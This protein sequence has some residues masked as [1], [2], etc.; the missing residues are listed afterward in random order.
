VINLEIVGSR[1]NGQDYVSPPHIFLTHGALRCNSIVKAHYVLNAHNE[2][3]LF[4][5]VRGWNWITSSCLVRPTN[6]P[7][8]ISWRKHNSATPYILSPALHAIKLQTNTKSE[9]HTKHN[10]AFCQTGQNY[11]FKAGPLEA[12][13]KNN[14]YMHIDWCGHPISFS[15]SNIMT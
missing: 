9:A 3:A 4:P 7:S 10:K 1:Y 6:N 8:K 13:T 2:N 15:V 14:K 5:S 12:W 11:F